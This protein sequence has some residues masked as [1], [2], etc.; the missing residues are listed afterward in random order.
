[1]YPEQLYIVFNNLDSSESNRN[2]TGKK[3]LS[4][5]KQA[6]WD[7]LKPEAPYKDKDLLHLFYAPKPGLFE[8]VIHRAAQ[9]E[10]LPKNPH[11]GSIRIASTLKTLPKDISGV[12]LI[13]YL[14]HSVH[15]QNLIN[16]KKTA[17]R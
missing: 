16:W 7:I 8:L 6:C 17:C 10:N 3:N 4:G 2:S 9:K 15:R 5:I 1:M 13:A 14:S 12:P 11:Q